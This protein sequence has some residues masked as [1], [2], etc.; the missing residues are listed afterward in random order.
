M[1]YFRQTAAWPSPQKQEPAVR[2]TLRS[3]RCDVQCILSGMLL[4]AMLLLMQ[5]CPSEPDQPKPPS[6]PKVSADADCCSIP[7]AGK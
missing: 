1:Y 2:S 5:G 6:A 4:A 3:E 7:N